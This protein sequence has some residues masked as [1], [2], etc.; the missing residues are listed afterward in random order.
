MI[1]FEIWMIWVWKRCISQIW[2]KKAWTQNLMFKPYFVPTDRYVSLPNFNPTRWCF[3]PFTVP[4]YSG[5]PPGFPTMGKLQSNTAFGDDWFIF[6]KSFCKRI[7][8]RSKNIFLS[9]L[10][11]IIRIGNFDFDHRHTRTRLICQK[12]RGMPELTH[13]VCFFQDSS[14]FFCVIAERFLCGFFLWLPQKRAD[15]C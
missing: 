14:N 5:F 6:C 11:K 12:N 8:F 2:V 9:N 4:S 15:F 3:C 1:F 10:N 13:V 7:I